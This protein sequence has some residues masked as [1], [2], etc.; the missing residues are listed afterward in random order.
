MLA[1]SAER[2]GEGTSA[3]M[4]L[5]ARMSARGARVAGLLLLAIGLAVIH[6]WPVA[7]RLDRVGRLNTGDGHWSIWSVTWVARALATKVNGYNDRIPADLSA[8]AEPLTFPSIESFR[9]LQERRARDV[10]FHLD[11]YDQRL[12]R[13]LMDRLDAH[14]ADLLPF[15]RTGDVWLSGIIGWP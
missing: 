4:L 11:R 2:R 14:K 8:I 15:N 12:R 1:G 7:F 3:R 6:T 13:R 9:I 5:Y 10:I